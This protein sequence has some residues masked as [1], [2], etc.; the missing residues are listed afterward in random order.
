MEKFNNITNLVSKLDNYENNL[1]RMFDYFEIDKEIIKSIDQDVTYICEGLHKFAYKVKVNN[2]D[3]NFYACKSINEKIDGEV[4]NDEQRYEILLN[5]IKLQRIINLLFLEYKKEM[6]KYTKEHKTLRFA[7]PID[8]ST[9]IKLY[10]NAIFHDNKYH[11]IVEE[12]ISDDFNNYINQNGEIIREDDISNY[13]S[14]FMHYSYIVTNGCIC[15]CDFQ[16]GKNL[17]TDFCIHSI[18][19]NIC[20]LDNSIKGINSCSENHICNEY[21]KFLNIISDKQ[22]IE[23][24]KYTQSLNSLKD[25]KEKLN[26]KDFKYKLFKHIEDYEDLKKHSTNYAGVYNIK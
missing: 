23:F 10:N 3:N 5:E 19:G 1:N 25:I 18:I 4:K 22:E 12:Y 8:Y 2:I 7:S 20:L 13:L 9:N 14:C 16:G 26:I 17:L 21:C 11:Y 24:H 6:F 15:I